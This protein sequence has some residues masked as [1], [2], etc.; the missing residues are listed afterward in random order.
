M[1]SAVR[2]HPLDRA[3]WRSW[4]AAHAA[5]STGVW[6]VMWRP[7]TGRGG[8]T[9][10]EAVTEALAFGWIDGQGRGLDD[11][12][13]MQWFCPRKRGSGWAGTNKV[14]VELLLREGRMTEA[15]QR[16]VDAAKADGSWSLL[17]EVEALVVPPDLEAAF[18][19]VPGSRE[20][21]DGFPPSAR[22]LMLTWLV[23]AKRAETRAARVADVAAAAGR[24]ERARS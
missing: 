12:R 20:H 6:L 11:E 18:A 9:Y 24:G 5:G 8:L 16:V 10:D 13:S 1:D 22:R 19:A 2:V 4:L 7:S 21:W 15:G 14:R 23:T 3:D 17:D